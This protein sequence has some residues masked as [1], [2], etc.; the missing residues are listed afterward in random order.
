MKR[1]V[2]SIGYDN[3]WRFLQISSY[4]DVLLYTVPTLII[5]NFHRRK[6]LHDLLAVKGTKVFRTAAKHPSK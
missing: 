1:T 6:K 3:V 5:N 2:T 4:V